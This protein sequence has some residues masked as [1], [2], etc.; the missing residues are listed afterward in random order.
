MSTDDGFGFRSTYRAILSTFMDPNAE[1]KTIKDF[2]LR[3]VQM[4]LGELQRRCM[5]TVVKDGQTVSVLADEIFLRL[6]P[7]DV[8]YL[9]AA[10]QYLTQYEVQ[11]VGE[12]IRDERRRK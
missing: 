5:N 12:V 11:R 3:E 7:E 4:F 1:K 2:H 10:E 9:W 8:R 6:T